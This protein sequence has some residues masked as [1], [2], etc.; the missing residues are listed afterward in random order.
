MLISDAILCNSSTKST[1][2]SNPERR[3]RITQFPPGEVRPAWRP[4]GGPACRRSRL[5]GPIRIATRS[6]TSS[7]IPTTR[8]S[9]AATARARCQRARWQG[10]RDP[11]PVGTLIHSKDPE[12]GELILIADLTTVGQRVLLAKG[13]RG[14]SATRTRRRRPIARGARCSWA[15]RARNRSP[16]HAEAA[17]R[18]R[19]RRLS[20]RRQVDADL[21]DLRGEA[22]DRDY[23]SP[24]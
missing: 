6:C 7:S 2:T 16:S 23:C 21:G 12:T 24:R 13:G 5:R 14:G 9:V 8:R 17:R 19:P 11:V 20:E 18:C 22:K 1:S 3:K 4:D 10:S 15:R